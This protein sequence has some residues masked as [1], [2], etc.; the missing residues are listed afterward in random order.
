MRRGGAV[1]GEWRLIRNLGLGLSLA[2]A[3]VAAW[4][5]LA[6]VSVSAAFSDPQ[7]TAG[8]PS[9]TTHNACLKEDHENQTAIG[10]GGADCTDSAP[11][12]DRT[13]DWF[14][15]VEPANGGAGGFTGTLHVT[16]DTGTVDWTT[17]SGPNNKMA[18]VPAPSVGSILDE[19]SGPVTGTTDIEFNLSGTCAALQT[20][21]TVPEIPAAAL[22]VV[23]AAGLIALG[24]RRRQS[25][26]A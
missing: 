22:V 6:S 3:S 17:F 13:K 24:Q 14:H 19:A 2:G 23:A 9:A 1:G 18:W 16:F 21:A 7:C 15:F 5:A 20:S 4:G 12:G 25:R 10:F 26:V 8:D 11:A